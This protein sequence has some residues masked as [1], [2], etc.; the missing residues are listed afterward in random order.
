MSRN[1]I[2]IFALLAIVFSLCHSCKEV[3]PNVDLGVVQNVDDTTYVLTNIQTPQTKNVLIEEL[4]GVKCANCPTGHQLVKDL[5][6]T[7]TGRVIG[8][9][10]HTVFLGR[11]YPGS[12]D[13]INAEAE[14][15]I[16]SANYGPLSEKPTAIIDRTYNS[17]ISSYLQGKNLWA[18]AVGT[19]I[20]KTTPVNIAI[21]KTYTDA[22]RELKVQVVAQFTEAVAENCRLVVALTEDSIVAEQLQPDGSTHDPN[23]VHLEVLRDFLTAN[24]GNSFG[25]AGDKGRVF[26]RNFTTTLNSNWS[27]KHMHIIAYVQKSTSSKEVLQTIEEKVK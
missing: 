2:A 27:E 1:K 15:L 16:S 18:T 6:N 26:V 25:T 14:D 13:M 8:I 12:P 10:M 19:Q 22:T 7:Y 21:T 20:S 9:A 17:S 4:T 23:Y 24:V 3:G 11:P 5:K